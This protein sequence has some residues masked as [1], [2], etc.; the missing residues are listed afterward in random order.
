MALDSPYVKM[1]GRQPN[2]GQITD[3]DS[4]PSGT[5]RHTLHVCLFC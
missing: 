2:L 4:N 1:K 5:Q 3:D